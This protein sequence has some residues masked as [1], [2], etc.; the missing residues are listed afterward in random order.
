MQIDNESNENTTVNVPFKRRRRVP[1]T[2]FKN[3]KTIVYRLT[4]DKGQDIST[5][6]RDLVK[7]VSEDQVH[8]EWENGNGIKMPLTEHSDIN[9]IQCI[10]AL[11]L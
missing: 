10:S 2:C 9:E 8:F 7:M 4:V 3:E 1:I 6:Q 11:F 5:L